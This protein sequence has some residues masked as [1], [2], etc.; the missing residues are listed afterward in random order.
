MTPPD[1]VQPIVDPW[2]VMRLG[3]QWVIERPLDGS[4]APALA[5]AGVAAAL[6]ES[7]LAFEGLLRPW[8][9]SVVAPLAESERGRFYEREWSGDVPHDVFWRR[10][11]DE[12]HDAPTPLHEVAARFDVRAYA[13]TQRSA[14]EPERAW[15]RLPNTL[16]V[17]AHPDDNVLHLFLM[18]EHTLFSAIDN[19]ALH[20]L[21]Q[22]L[23]EPCMRSWE[24]RLGP[25]IESHWGEAVFRYGYRDVTAR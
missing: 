14:R 21:N 1:I 23:L 9:V 4:G 10:V 2:R 25:I 17:T 15:L 24:A 5:N 11:V 3:G 12:V 7:C 19:A 8:H 13:R 18:M 16:T 20:A 6:G 22:P